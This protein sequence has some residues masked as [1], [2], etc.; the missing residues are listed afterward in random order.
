[1]KR[2]LLALTAGLTLS[3]VSLAGCANMNPFAAQASVASQG[4]NA[5][6]QAQL[7][8]GLENS[9][10]AVKAWQA[11]NGRYPS[12]SEFATIQGAAS[13]SGVTIT[14]TPTASGFC[15]TGTS[16]TTPPATGVWREPGGMQPAGSV[17]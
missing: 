13:N 7:L 3:A 9:A 8:G 16:S 11:V 2:R 12:A 17:C 15:L 1:M 6:S 10:M 5:A 14:Y 4:V